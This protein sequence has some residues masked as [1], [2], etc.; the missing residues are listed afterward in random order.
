MADQPNDALF[1]EIDDELRQEQLHKAWK[2]YGKYVSAAA[3]VLVVG[4]A[5]FQGWR[6][7]DIN[8]RSA[9]GERFAA[10]V[11]LAAAANTEQ[12]LAAFQG[13][14]D[15][16]GGG[17][18]MLARFRVAGLLAKS[19]DAAGAAGA[20]VGLADD[21]SLNAVYRDMA[22]V[23]GAMQ[24][25]N[26]IGVGGP[27]VG[28]IAA[29]DTEDN[30]WRHSA[31]EISALVALAKGDTSGAHDLLSGLSTDATAPSGIRSRAAELLTIIG[32]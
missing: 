18:A 6:S 28:R 13:I 25:L 26:S 24:E 22:V 30:P 2:A 27:L 15:E 20:Y 29:I 14:A 4:V 31:R 19:G 17:Y 23:L 11:G 21:S 5:G 1:Q 12:A 7:W 32:K 8:A 16:A 3:L 9:E 10:A